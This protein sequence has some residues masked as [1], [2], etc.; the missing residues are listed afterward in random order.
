MA[1]KTLSATQ[2]NYLKSILNK[3]QIAKLR[4]EIET[5]TPLTEKTWL[6]K[7]LDDL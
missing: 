6:L 5:A 1:I 3:D 2:K 4:Q 7:Q